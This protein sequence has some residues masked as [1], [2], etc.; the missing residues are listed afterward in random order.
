MLLIGCQEKSKEQEVNGPLQNK[1]EYEKLRY[2]K[3]V[4]WPKAYREQDTILLD[5]ILGEDFQMVSADGTW[6]DKAGQMERIKSAPMDNDH[7]EFEIKRLEVKDN[8]TAIVAGTGHVIRNGQEMIY[9]SSNVLIKRG[10][11]WKAVLSHVSGITELEVP[12][13]HTIAKLPKEAD[14]GYLIGEWIRTNEADGRETFEQWK[15]LSD[16]EY[17]G[18][19]YTLSAGDTVWKEDIKLIQEADH[20]DYEVL[21]Q[22]DSNPTPFKVTKVERNGFECYNPVNEFPK[23]IRYS[24]VGDSLLAQI[25]DGETTIDFNFVKVDD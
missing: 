17:S 14:F 20:W 25:S 13:Q 7:F 11:V 6:S 8:G 3:E 9:Q 5:R 23:T 21:G 1:E 4:E 15:K 18:M 10:E 2:L 12:H 24:R 22:G 19:G 16:L